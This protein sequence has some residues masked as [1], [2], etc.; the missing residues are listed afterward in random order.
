MF[1]CE[2]LLLSYEG[3]ANKSMDVRAKQRLCLERRPLSLTLTLA[4]SPHVISIVSR[5]LKR[6]SNAARLKS[7]AKTLRVSS[8]LREGKPLPFG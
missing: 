3:R 4:V 5:F 6:N 8:T 1:D 7:K 2:R